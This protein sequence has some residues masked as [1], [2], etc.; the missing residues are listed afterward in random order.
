MPGEVAA[1]IFQDRTADFYPAGL[2]N[3]AG[4]WNYVKIAW[5]D[6]NND[7]WVDLLA[8]GNVLRNN[9]GN[10]FSNTGY[11]PGENGV[12]GD[13]N[14]DGHLDL[15]GYHRKWLL[16]SNGSGGFVDATSKIPTFA[17]TNNHTHISHGAAWADLNND[18]DLDLYIGGYEIF[19]DGTTFPDVV[20]TYNSATQQFNNTWQE[21]V[22]RARG[23]TAADFDRDGDQDVYV[24]NYRLQPNRL[25]RNNGSGVM[26]DVAPAYGASGAAH[27][28]GSAWGD[29]D[30]DG[31]L[32]LFVGNFSHPGQEPS[33]FLRNMGPS[34]SYH[35]QNMKDLSGGDWQ[36]SYAS[37]AL[38]DYDNDGDLDLYFTSVYAGNNPRLY[39]NDGNWNFTNVSESVG[40]GGLGQTYQAA[41]ADVDNDGDL[42][43]VTAGK[44]LI[45]NSQSNGN[46]WLK[47]NLE[48]NG[49]TSNRSAIG[50]QVRVYADGE[51]I[52]R[53]VEGG[54]GEGNQNDL[55]MH[56]GLG[57]HTGLVDVEIL[58]PDGTQETISGAPTNRFLEINQ[59]E[60]ITLAVVDNGSPES[61]LHSYTLTATG[62]GITTLSK[63]TIDG[64]VHQVFHSG[65]P[66]EWRGDGSALALD[67]T[68]SHVIF[69]NLRLPDSGGVAWDYENFP[70]GPPSKVTEETIT[71]GGDS[72]MGTLNNYDDSVVPIWDTYL[73]FGAPS[74]EDE[75]VELMQL[76]VA[77]GDGFSVDLTLLASSYYDPV[78]GEVLVIKH[79]YLNF[80][81]DPLIAGDANGDG[82]VDGTDASILAQHWLQQTGATWADGDFN[83]DGAVNDL[84]AT[85]LAAN[86]QLTAAQASVPEPATLSLLLTGLIG[87]LIMGVTQHRTK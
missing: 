14:N 25:W 40:L 7:G 38:G 63:F 87:S 5:G 78:S 10:S 23:V 44:L 46:R 29:F 28:I 24:S 18:G 39:R 35:F 75:T 30:N 64:E 85:L 1:Q 74:T 80:T 84:D 59:E 27:S 48:G 22:Y 62:T 83:R 17:L 68:D 11:S 77:D 69:G 9:G 52:T 53:Q 2:G 12:W 21:Q 86:W 49:E 13:F 19:T 36:E 37:P 79:D 16:E 45:N 3:D 55:T 4:N 60:A 26:T 70:A 15:F 56:F 6:Y 31:Y 42:D 67:T 33:H 82:S 81:L 58:W 57:N 51:I 65:S 61:G 34:G 20:L 47:I 66:S 50:A 41:W 73:K 71:G 54:T 32:D 43:L 8:G 76:V 72:G